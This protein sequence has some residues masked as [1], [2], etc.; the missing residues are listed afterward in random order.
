MNQYKL[1]YKQ[2]NIL[3]EVDWNA[4]LNTP[5]MPPIDL[6]YYMPKLYLLKF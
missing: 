3:D 6:K 1:F 4:W 5:G 2:K